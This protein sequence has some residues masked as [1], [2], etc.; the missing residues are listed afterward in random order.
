MVLLSEL[1][2]NNYKDYTYGIEKLEYEKHTNYNTKKIKYRLTNNGDFI[3]NIMLV[4]NDNNEYILFKN[5]IKN[6]SVYI[7]GILNMKYDIDV[8]TF[9][10][11]EVY[12]TH[13]KK[14]TTNLSIMDMYCL[15][16]HTID[17]VLEYNIYH[18][19]NILLYANK[20]IIYEPLIEFNYNKRIVYP[21]IN[22]DIE[23]NIIEF[24][25]EIN[26]IIIVGINEEIKIIYV[27]DDI[28][29]FE[30]KHNILR[31]NSFINIKR[32][33]INIK[34]KYN[35]NIYTIKN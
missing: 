9:E 29:K 1:F 18:T 7:D 32:I 23:S 6:I 34:N 5:N 13:K 12:T 25:N 20:I 10:L 22:I 30:Y 15:H 35:V 31:I 4:C 24:E 21:Y 17:I 33:K 14:Y 2:Y 28:T 16:K 27:N 8:Y 3:D 11:L 19:N 26:T